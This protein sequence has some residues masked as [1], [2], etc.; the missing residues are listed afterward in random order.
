MDIN[1][2]DKHGHAPL[3]WAAKT[4]QMETAKLLI[5]NGADVNAKGNTG[6]TALHEASN[7]QREM[8]KLLIKNRANVNAKNDNGNTSLHRASAKGASGNNQ[9]SYSESSECEYQKQ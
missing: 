9:I 1:I 5:K 3:F 4:G 8:V 2:K 7:G 6:V